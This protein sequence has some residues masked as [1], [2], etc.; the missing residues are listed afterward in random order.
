MIEDN[1]V[2]NH[3]VV[4]KHRLITPRPSHL[5]LGAQE[6]RGVD[7]RLVPRVVPVNFGQNTHEKPSEGEEESIKCNNINRL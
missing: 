4:Q 2:V 6:P 1:W 5:V 7:P 3:D